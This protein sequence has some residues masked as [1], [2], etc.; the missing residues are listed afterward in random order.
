MTPNWQGGVGQIIHHPESSTVGMLWLIRI[1]LGHGTTAL[2]CTQVSARATRGS[3]L[4]GRLTLVGDAEPHMILNYGFR[5]S[6]SSRR[7]W[8]VL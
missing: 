7:R 2:R 6:L 8:S 5:S 1:D 4:E 3:T